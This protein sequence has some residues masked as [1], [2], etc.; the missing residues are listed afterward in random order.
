MFFVLTV[1]SNKRK[2][3]KKISG[4]YTSEID[5][6]LSDFDRS[7]V[8]L[9]DQ[10]S[11]IKKHKQIFCFRDNSCSVIKKKSLWNFSDNKSSL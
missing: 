3:Y 4:A 11:E 10:L 7:H 6:S 8:L 2:P 9:S 1:F 5:R